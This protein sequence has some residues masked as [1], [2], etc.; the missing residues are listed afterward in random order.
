MTYE[1]MLEFLDGFFESN[2]NSYGLR[3]RTL[4]DIGCGKGYF[5]EELRK[6]GILA[7]G[8]DLCPRRGY[9]HL[10]RGDAKNLKECFGKRKFDV[11]TANGVLGYGGQLETLLI[12][13]RKK[14]ERLMESGSKEFA[15][16]CKE[17]AIAILRSCYEQLNSPGLFLNSEDNYQLDSVTYTKK[18][19]KE[20]GFSPLGLNKN[21]SVMIK[22]PRLAR[23]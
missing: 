18:D 20:I 14:A 21:G 2:R 8:L 9:K 13:D 11:I 4:L 22:P 23:R 10:H 1:S 16:E 19:A 15:K 7:E 6:K 5:V 12:L 3:C 17:G